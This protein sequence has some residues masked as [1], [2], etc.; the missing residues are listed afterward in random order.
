MT[1]ENA[2]ESTP[3]RFTSSSPGWAERVTAI[4]NLSELEQDLRVLVLSLV[5]RCGCGQIATTRLAWSD[6]SVETCERCEIVGHSW[7]GKAGYEACNESFAMAQPPEVALKHWPRLRPLNATEGRFAEIGTFWAEANA[8]V[9]QAIEHDES[10]LRWKEI[11]NEALAW[12]SSL[13]MEQRSKIEQRAGRTL[14]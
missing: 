14:P 2:T 4:E 1:T 12:W 10:A 7:A 9:R 8:A 5:P 6:H 11:I 3:I 13:P